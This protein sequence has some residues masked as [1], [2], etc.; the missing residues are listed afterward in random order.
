MK[1]RASN[2][3]WGAACAV[4]HGIAWA[5]HHV[6]DDDLSHAQGRPP[7]TTAEASHPTPAYPSACSLAP[8]V[9]IGHL[10]PVDR[11]ELAPGHPAGLDTETHRATLATVAAGVHGATVAAPIANT[12]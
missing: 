9:V 3:F 5:F 2:C 6:A 4:R 10:H 1:T 8:A 12:V 7:L 11:S